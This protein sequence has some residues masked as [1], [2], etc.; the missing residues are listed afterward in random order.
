MKFLVHRGERFLHCGILV[1]ATLLFLDSA[2]LDDLLT[3]MAVVHSDDDVIAHLSSDLQKTGNP[4]V[5]PVSEGMADSRYLGI[6]P[7]DIRPRYLILDQDSPSTND[8]SFEFAGFHVF[9]AHQLTPS[10]H[11]PKFTSLLYLKLHTLLI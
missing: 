3:T 6:L 4:L 2:N 1:F 8:E 9:P 10:Y 5:S 11:S 7:S